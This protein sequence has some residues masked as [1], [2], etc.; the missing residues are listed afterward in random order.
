VTSR[1]VEKGGVQPLQRQSNEPLQ[2]TGAPTCCPDFHVPL[3]R[4]LLNSAVRRQKGGLMERFA[5]IEIVPHFWELIEASRGDGEVMQSVLRGLTNDDLHRFEEEF[6]GAISE[7]VY[8]VIGEHGDAH[9]EEEIAGWVVSRG[10]AFYAE[11]WAHPER[12]PA[13]LPLHPESFWG[14]AG[15]QLDERRRGRPLTVAKSVW[16]VPWPKA[17]GGDVLGQRTSGQ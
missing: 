2:Q 13:E 1:S 14:M 4:R 17:R 15:V 16:L 8:Q 9:E 3:A 11:V 7:L 6:E 10:L 5:E 12:F